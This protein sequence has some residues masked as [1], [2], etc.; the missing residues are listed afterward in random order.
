MSMERLYTESAEWWPLL[1]PP[2][3]YEEEGPLYVSW[4]AHLLGRSPQSLME[5]G[6]GGGHLAQ[7]YP[8]ACDVLLVDLSEPMLKVSRRLNPQKEHVC[9]DMRTM[10]L[11]RTVDAV[12]IHDA[13]MYMTSK[14]DVIATLRTAYTHLVPGGALVVIPDVIRESFWERTLT[15]GNG[16]EQRAIQLMEWHWDPD[17]NDDTFCVEFSYLLREGQQVRSVHEQHIM[18]LFGFEQWIAMLQE[19][20]FEVVPRGPEH[21]AD[22]GGEIFWA[23][24]P[25]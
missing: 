8:K 12:L 14:A 16:D 24:R 2:D 17:P 4:L 15:G 22:L 7:H 25:V 20:G 5:L 18:G 9:A 1:S 10:R 11:E 6:S 23:R 19:A 21:M 3:T 13:I